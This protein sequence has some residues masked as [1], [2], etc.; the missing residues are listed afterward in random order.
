MTIAITGDRV[1]LRQDDQVLAGLLETGDT[2]HLAPQAM[3]QSQ[4]ML[5]A[6]TDATLVREAPTGQADGRAYYL[7]ADGRGEELR[8]TDGNWTTTE[9][10]QWLFRPDRR[11]LCISPRPPEHPHPFLTS[12]CASVVLSGNTIT[13]TPENGTAA[14]G[15]LSKGRPSAKRP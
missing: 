14:H 8:R 11:W 5:R 6:L 9:R 3:A 4:R 10:V 12:H 7:G 2:R 15:T 13:L 1:L